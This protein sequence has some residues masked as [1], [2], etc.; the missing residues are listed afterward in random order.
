[1][2]GRSDDWL[3]AANFTTSIPNNVNPLSILPVKIPL[4][5]FLD[6]G[7]NAAA[8]KKDAGTTKFLF[9]AGLQ[10]SLFKNVLNIYV[11]LLYSKV[12]SDY[13]KSYKPDTKFLRN[14]SFSIDL[15]NI[16][17]PNPVHN[18]IF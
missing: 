18:I 17:L 1:R 3:I 7:T 15:Q 13:F 14:I 4:K 16:R 9:D 12:Y 11:P 2:E 5:A 6:I 10:V 8:W